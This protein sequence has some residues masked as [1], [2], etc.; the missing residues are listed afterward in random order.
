MSR[1]AAFTSRHSGATKTV[2][3][4]ITFD[5]ITEANFYDV[6]LR[7]GIPFEYQVKFTFHDGVPKN[8]K[9]KLLSSHG[10]HEAGCKIDYRFVLDGITYL[11]DTK[12]SVD[13]I[14][15]AARA[16]YWRLKR[17]LYDQGD[18]EYTALVSV[19]YKDVQALAKLAGF[20]DKSHFWARFHKI[21]L[22]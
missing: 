13:H 22:F 3:H 2:R 14:D 6:L 19:G 4:G 5:S 9:V 7:V 21:E 11:V 10:I 17:M 12:G 8:K 15:T 16:R 18:A 20:P 1:A